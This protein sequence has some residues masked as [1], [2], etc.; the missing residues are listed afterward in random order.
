MGGKYEIERGINVKF[1]DVES[2][3]YLSEG[4]YTLFKDKCPLH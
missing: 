2:M 1:T 4:S 3:I